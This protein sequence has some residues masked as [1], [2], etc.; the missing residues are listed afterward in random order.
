[1]L[2]QNNLYLILSCCLF[3]M[4][5]NFVNFTL[6]IVVFCND[7]MQILLNIEL[8]T[9]STELSTNWKQAV[10]KNMFTKCNRNYGD[11]RG[12][13]QQITQ[14]YQQCPQSYAQAVETPIDQRLYVR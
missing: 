13:L 6:R 12:I 7:C 3:F 8:S 10:E 2:F 9:I 14:G 4:R 5:A 11:F 1:M